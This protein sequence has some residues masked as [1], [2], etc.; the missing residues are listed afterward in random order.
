MIRLWR[1]LIEICLSIYWFH[2]LFYRLIL[3][4]IFT[5]YWIKQKTLQTIIEANFPCCIPAPAEGWMDLL[6]PCHEAFNLMLRPVVPSILSGKVIFSPG[7]NYLSIVE[8]NFCIW[9]RSPCLG[10]CPKVCHILP[11]FKFTFSICKSWS[12]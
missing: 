1:N 11:Y 6:G 5:Y 10:L 12:I 2:F 3:A 8:I 9:N 4:C 7:Q